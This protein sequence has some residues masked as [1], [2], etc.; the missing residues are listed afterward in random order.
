MTLGT[1]PGKTRHVLILKTDLLN[2]TGH[3][4]T[5]VIPLTNIIVPDAAPLRVHIPANTPG[6][7]RASD[8]LTL[9]DQLRIIDN[10]RLYHPTSGT[11]LKYI[12]PATD[13]MLT[14]T[15]H[16]VLLVLELPQKAL[17]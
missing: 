10:Q 13:A 2:Q 7:L 5:L 1:E 4:P 12:G 3:P 16:C 9:I 6:F 14:A 11:L 17:L 15:N 8:T